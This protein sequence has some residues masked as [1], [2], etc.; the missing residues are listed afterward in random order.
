MS[1]NLD[2]APE[3]QSH[4]PR[5]LHVLNGDTTREKLERS[6]V[7]GTFAV[8]ADVL[9][10]GPV[11]GEVSA[12]RWREVR[13]RYHLSVGNS[14]IEGPL[15]Y[16]QALE[17]YRGW[18]AA[19]ER[20]AE[21][22]EVVIWCEH[23]LFDQL[24]LIRHLDWFGRRDPGDTRLSLICIGSY[25][26]MPEFKGLGQLSPDQLA[27]LLDTR[28]P[29]TQRQLELARSAWRAFTAPEPTGLERVLRNDASA[30]PFLERALRRL[31]Q[32]FP[33]TRNGLSR[34]EEEIL[35]LLADAPRP[36]PELFQLM[37]DPEDAFYI[38]DASFWTVLRG[39]A[40]GS[41]PAV[42][43]DLD[44][45]KRGY[46]PNGT[47]RISPVGRA[48]LAGEADWIRSRGIDRWIGGVHLAGN[49]AMWRRDAQEQ[50]VLFT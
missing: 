23:D 15:S 18:D 43:L 26:G 17:H 9:H 6:E 42:E 16:E 46:L 20:Y 36:V 7:P 30:L 41:A 37:H 28:Q 10:E 39:L 2:E 12:E 38:G 21:Y 27:S 50:P 44:V 47:A 49:G 48:L 32:E 35:R 4:T 22:E 24:L 40:S 19:L 33:S 29:V 31:L 14:P 34:T 13:V 8:W 5:L 11:P 3:E 45:G 25:P 1:R